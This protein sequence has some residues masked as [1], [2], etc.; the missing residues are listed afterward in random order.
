MD[1][2]AEDILQLINLEAIKKLPGAKKRAIIDLIEGTIEEEDH[3]EG[4]SED[5]EEEDTEEELQI[6][7]ER[8]QEYLKNPQDVV[9]WNDFMK[10]FSTPKR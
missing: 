1:E 4:I 6:L 8:L 9:S 10:E 3:N 5:Y 7:E 2:V